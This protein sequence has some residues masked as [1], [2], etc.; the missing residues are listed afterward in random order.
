MGVWG[1]ATFPVVAVVV[2]LVR[3][4]EPRK[5]GINE[6][7]DLDLGLLEDEGADAESFKAEDVSSEMAASGAETFLGDSDKGAK[8]DSVAVNKKS[9]VSTSIEY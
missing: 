5:T 7:L 3:S 1:V 6:V 4:G 8:S 9:A 2:L